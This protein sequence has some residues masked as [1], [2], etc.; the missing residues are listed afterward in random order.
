MPKEQPLVEDPPVERRIGT[1]SSG[2]SI[3]ESLTNHMSESPNGTLHEKLLDALAEGDPQE[4]ASLI[5]AGADVRYQD[6]HGY[7]AL[8]HAVHGRDV[9]GD[10]R[11]IELMTLLIRSGVPL[12]GRSTYSESGVR[13]LSRL[14]RFDAVQVLLQAGADPGDLE[15]TPLIGAAAFGSLTDVEDAV[16]SGA[17][18]E[19]RD[20]WERT[21]WLV[22]VQA[23]DVPKASLLLERGADRN[24][25]GRCGKPPLFYA[26]EN[27]HPLMLR[28][29]LENGADVRATDDFG[30]TALAAAAE[31]GD[32][33][34]VDVLLRA[35]ADANQTFA[36]GSALGSARTRE[37]ALRLLEAGADPQELS[38]GGRRAILGYAPD[39]DEELLR[40]SAEEFR[41]FRSRRFGRRNPEAMNNPFWEGMIRAGVNAYRAA[42]RVEGERR[43]GARHGPIWCAERF[44][45]SLTLLGDGRIV[46]VG[47]EHEDGYDPDF[48]IYN[49][50]FVHAPGGVTIYGYPEAVFPP[51]DFHTATLI[52]GHVY[53]IG[54]LGYQGTRRFGETPVYR[55]DARTFRMERLVTT[56]DGPGWIYKHRGVLLGPHEIQVTGGK[57][58]TDVG[59]VEVHSDNRSTFILNAETLAWSL[60]DP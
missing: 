48:C 47:G 10:P 54:S 52:G 35:G 12:T 1:R 53:L 31:E 7:D 21:P 41:A 14:G 40:V 17:D 38:F 34:A 60:N 4:V 27:G 9:L 18:L 28:W 55:L 42:V 29:L 24:A 15:M 13:V 46:Q 43:L 45:Q 5:S 11:L 57:V 8:I 23:G 51:T 22:A 58:A 20:F 56:G 30:S 3:G 50:V 59:G 25:R 49:D 32:A 2:E 16:R 6:E 19:G 37:A 44:G 26:I 36:S 39:P 33:D